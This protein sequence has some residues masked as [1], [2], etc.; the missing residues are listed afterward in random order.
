MCV[1]AQ[2]LSRALV[3]VALWTV[4][5]QAPLSTGLPRQEN[6]M[7]CHFLLQGIFPTQGA[8]LF[9]LCLLQWQAGGFFTTSTTWEALH[10][11]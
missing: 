3:F 10:E 8:N 5:C 4:A 1:H 6:W 11:L 9:L 2:S 7:G